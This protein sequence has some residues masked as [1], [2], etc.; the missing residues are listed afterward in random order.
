MKI[1]R[2]VIS[3]DPKILTYL[4]I[5]LTAGV[6]LM[7]VSGPL[8]RTQGEPSVQIADGYQPYEVETNQTIQTSHTGYTYEQ[9]LERRLEEVLSLVEGAGKVRVLVTFS[10]GRETIF[11]VDRNINNSTMQEQDAQGGTRYQHSQ[12]EQ[13]NT[14][15]ITDR[16]GVDRP[17]VVQE[18]PPIIGG[19]MIIAEG[20]D[21]VLVQDALIRAT[22]T[23]LGIDINRVQVLKMR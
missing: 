21:N 10:Q 19:V 12:Q 4:G 9:L 23:L 20:G 1:L 2:K 5:A 7:L 6:F 14:L 8:M 15:I 16:T 18:N 3:K 17:L 13:D 11:A 22:S